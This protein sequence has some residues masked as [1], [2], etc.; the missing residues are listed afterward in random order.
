MDRTL[1]GTE[2]A[3]YYRGALEA[4]VSAFAEGANAQM[5]NSIADGALASMERREQEDAESKEEHGT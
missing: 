1:T 4:I 5:L 3:E 2:K